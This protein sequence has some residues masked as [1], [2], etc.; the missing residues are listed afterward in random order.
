MVAFTILFFLLL[1]SI[2][3]AT[4][5]M[6]AIKGVDFFDRTRAFYRRMERINEKLDTIIGLL[7][8]DDKL[9]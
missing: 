1:V 4:A 2:M 6:V 5:I 8:R 7:T 9:R 3:T